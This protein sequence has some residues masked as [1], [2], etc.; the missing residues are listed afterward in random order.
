MFKP[1]NAAVREMRSDIETV[2]G[3]RIELIA[4]RRTLDRAPV[5]RAEIET[6]VDRLMADREAEAR[7]IFVPEGLTRQ[8]GAGFMTDANLPTIENSN[9]IG[10]LILFGFGDAVRKSLIA[11]AVSASTGK[12]FSTAQREAER[13]RIAK[14][15]AAQE[16]IEEA[17]IRS[18]EE[19]GISSVLRRPDADPALFLLE[20]I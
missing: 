12:S 1:K 19:A 13:D 15:L 18:L 5:S 7:A 17:L 6:R 2:R 10:A 8:G 3:K 14:D 9:L 20:K 16:R 4:E 11:E